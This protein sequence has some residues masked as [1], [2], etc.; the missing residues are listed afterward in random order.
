MIIAKDTILEVR[1]NRSGRFIGI[2]K[3]DFDTEDEWYPIA[4]HQDELVNGLTQSWGRG[5]NVPCRKTMCRISPV[6]EDGSKVEPQENQPAEQ[7]TQTKNEPTNND[8]DGG[9]ETQTS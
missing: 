3:E 8:Q 5:E 1:H 4:V 9:Q 6:N 7:Q 2:A